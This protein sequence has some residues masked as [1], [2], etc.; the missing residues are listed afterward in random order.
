VLTVQRCPEAIGKAGDRDAALPS[1]PM[2]AAAFWSKSSAS[3]IYRHT[4]VAERWPVCFMMERSLFP[5]LA[6]ALAR[7]ERSECPAKSMGSSP[8]SS[9]HRFTMSATLCAVSRDRRVPPPPPTEGDAVN[10]GPARRLAGLRHEVLDQLRR[11]S[12]VPSS[13]ASTGK[14]E[15]ERGILEGVE[16]K[17]VAGAASGCEV[18]TGEDS[19]ALSKAPSKKTPPPRTTELARIALR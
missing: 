9:A 15:P 1:R 7:P 12:V 11:R 18:R 8:A 10:R 4:M 17:V 3:R 6:A 2:P 13:R 19:G 16:M 14:S 5:A